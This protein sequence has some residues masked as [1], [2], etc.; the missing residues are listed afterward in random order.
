MA[1][2]VVLGIAVV[3]FVGVTSPLPRIKLFSLLPVSLI[4]KWLVAGVSKKLT[5]PQNYF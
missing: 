4:N 3:F 2:T 1:V 5:C